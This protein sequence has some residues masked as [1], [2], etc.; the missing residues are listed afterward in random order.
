MICL[1][2]ML[3]V[4]AATT[5]DILPTVSG[6]R[7][8]IYEYAKNLMQTQGL[9]QPPEAINEL[10]HAIFRYRRNTLNANQFN[11]NLM[12]AKAFESQAY[13]ITLPNL[14]G[15]KDTLVLIVGVTNAYEQRIVSAV[16]IGNM[17]DKLAYYVDTNHN[18]DFT[19]DG[20]FIF[21]TKTTK[22]VWLRSNLPIRKT[23][24]NISCTTW[25]WYLNTW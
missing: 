1:G 20:S 22:P 4:G 11:R 5:Q 13:N 3:L 2:V 8:D 23:A 19:D 14:T 18:F 7:V 9:E 10:P 6:Q 15:M 12:G 16:I 17:R 21:L 25:L 24:T